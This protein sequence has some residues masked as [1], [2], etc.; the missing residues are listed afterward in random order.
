MKITKILIGLA[1]VNLAINNNNNNNNQKRSISQKSLI[2]KKELSN[3]EK[4]LNEKEDADDI[5]KRIKIMN[6]KLSESIEIIFDDFPL[7]TNKEGKI[8]N[9]EIKVY[10]AKVKGKV[11]LGEKPWG[12]GCDAFSEITTETEI[13]D[14][15]M[16]AK[17]S[18]CK[19]VGNNCVCDVEIT[20]KGNCDL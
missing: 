17:T 19:K 9:T 20:T 14:C 10:E 2:N 1:A 8:Q 7:F 12:V 6:K 15:I 18:N 11:D 16:T 4:R 5:V 3:K 13:G